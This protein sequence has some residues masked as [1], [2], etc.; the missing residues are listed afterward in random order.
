MVDNKKNAVVDPVPI[1]DN[2]IS[3]FNY[4][5]ADDLDAYARTRLMATSQDFLYFSKEII[6]ERQKSKLQK[7]V[8]FRFRRHPSYNLPAFR[9]TPIEQFIHK[10][11][12]ALLS[13]QP[14]I[15]ET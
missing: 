13:L 5:M 2:G 9:L 15:R 6:T 8:N 11:V 3:L 10:R 7:L 1:F 12:Q 4:A 14:R